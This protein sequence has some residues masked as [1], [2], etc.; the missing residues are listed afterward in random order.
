M[1][2]SQAVDCVIVGAGVA[3]LTAASEM[4]RAGRTFV[5]L[6]ARDRVGGRTHGNELAGFPVDLGGQWLGP[7]QIHALALCRELG[8]DLFPQ[9]AA[10]LDTLILDGAARRYMPGRFQIPTLS[11]LAF[12]RA[13]SALDTLSRTLG[14]PVDW[15]TG[16]ARRHDQMTFE[17]WIVSITRNATARD[18]LR[19]I[20]RAV[21]SAEA[22]Q[23][24]LLFVLNYIAQAGSFAALTQ[25][26]GG[27][28]QDRVVGGAF[29]IARLLAARLPAGS[30]VLNAPVT[31]IAQDG[32]EV[33][34]NAA[35]RAYSAAKVIVAIA[36]TLTLGIAFDPPLPGDRDQLARRMPMGSVVKA[37]LSYPTPFWRERGLSDTVNSDGHAFAPIMDASPPSGEVGILVGFFEGDHARGRASPKQRRAIAEAAVAAGLGDC[38]PSTGYVEHDWTADPWSR[39]CYVGLAG[40]GVLST[41]GESLSAPVGHVH[42][43]G[44]ET[45]RV[46]TGYIDGAIESGRRAAAEILDVL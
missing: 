31:G 23:L 1:R 17:G 44:T 9:H 42:W 34:V 37:P 12:G 40:P 20:A 46:W 2:K 5:V 16:A 36:P 18:A 25:V 27:A 6:E 21:F 4:A 29:Q 3:G 38:P 22:H 19:M 13:A 26:V 14:S 39:G 43:A 30:V 33:T 15:S 32:V 28:Q 35:D 7:T 8:L 41:L 11:L 10:G 24:S 45:A